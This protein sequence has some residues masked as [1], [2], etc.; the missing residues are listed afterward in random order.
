[1]DELDLEG[2]LAFPER[3][4]SRASDLWV[5]ASLDYKQPNR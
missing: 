4:L 3:I 1:V 5:R 2:I